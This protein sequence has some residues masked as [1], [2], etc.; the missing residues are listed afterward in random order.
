MMTDKT[1]IAIIGGG[2]AGLTLGISLLRQGYQVRVYSDPEDLMAASPAAHGIS[3]IKG[4]LES[5]QELFGKKLQ[6]HRGFESYLT[7]LEKIAKVSRPKAVWKTEATEKFDDLH[8]FQKDFGR[9]YRRDFIGA[10]QIIL[11]AAQSDCFATARYPGDWWV[12]PSYLLSVMTKALQCLGGHIVY[13]RVLGMKYEANKFQLTGQR[14][15]YE[16]VTLVV[17]AGLGTVA[18]MEC[19]GVQLDALYGVSG[20]TFKADGDMAESLMVKKTY[21][22]AASGP[23]IH[24]GSTSDPACA[25]KPE[26]VFARNNSIASEMNEAKDLWQKILHQNADQRTYPNTNPKTNPKT[27]PPATSVNVRWGVRV[28]N[29]KRMPMCGHIRMMDYPEADLWINTAYYKSGIIL[30]WLEA[31]MLA[32]EIITSHQQSK[33]L[34]TH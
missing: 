29:R 13:D 16:V 18:L 20:Y 31:E 15:I 17:A 7:S 8:H 30:T 1:D 5:D 28:R 2:F 25:I 19:L 11:D 23:S 4:I 32:Q 10:K 24:W 34:N 21:G 12:D 33:S 26:A 27:N 22:L 3:T 14:S 6:G 9:I